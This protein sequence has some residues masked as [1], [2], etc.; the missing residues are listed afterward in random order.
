MVQNNFN[1]FSFFHVLSFFREKLAKDF[2]VEIFDQKGGPSGWKFLD[3][4]TR[5]LPN[6]TVPEASMKKRNRVEKESKISSSD[7]SSNK[8][9]KNESSSS[10]SA[11]A[12]IEKPKIQ[13]KKVDPKKSKETPDQLRN[14]A[15]LSAVQGNNNGNGNA[16]NVDGVLIEDIVV[17]VAGG[18]AATAGKRIKVLYVGRL[19]TTNKVFDSCSNANKPFAFR[20][21]GGE[22]IRGWDIGCAGMAIGG[23]RRLT[24]P[25]EKGYGRA[26]A[27][28]TIPGNATL[29]FDVTL[30]DC[31]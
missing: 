17:G 28:P 26:G 29:I 30:V 12:V 27:P 14:K 18:K 2:G 4:S 9:P 20:L 25:P 16:R 24:I 10:S 6:V 1:L 19:K 7:S 5:K 3:G 21:G 31:S 15:V 8:R 22:V 23:K 13:L 11:S